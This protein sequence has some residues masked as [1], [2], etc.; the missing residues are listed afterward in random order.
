MLQLAQ[1]PDGSRFS[2]AASC[3]YVA[4]LIPAARLVIA[5]VNRQ[6]PFT[7]APVDAADID[8]MVPAD[9]PPASLPV[10]AAT[11]ADERIGEHVAALVE[12]GATLQL[13]LGSTPECV[14]ARLGAHRDLGFHAG[15]MSDAAMALMQRGAITNARKPRDA[16]QSVTG[17]LLGSAQ[18]LRWAHANDAVAL[19]PVSHTHDLRLA[20]SMP[21]FTAINSAIEVDLSARPI[22]SS[23]RDAMSGRSAVPSISRA[24]RMPR[25]AGWRSSPCPRH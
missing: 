3:D 11:P 2:L 14:A 17:G 15:V 16:G 7:D 19:R 20:A 18:L 5:E 1:S 22:P 21:K 24:P 10:P 9:Y 8:I 25:R 4:A 23:P 12:D 6:A 13:G